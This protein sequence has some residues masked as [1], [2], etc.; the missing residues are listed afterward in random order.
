MN[1]DDKAV[2]IR[3]PK[4]VLLRLKPEMY[5]VV[6]KLATEDLRSINGEIEF[7]LKEWLAIRQNRSNKESL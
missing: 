7:A 4:K 1:E 3:E 6:K 5:E 2:E